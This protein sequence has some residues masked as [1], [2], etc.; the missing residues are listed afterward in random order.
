MWVVSFRSPHLR[1]EVQV[2][3]KRLTS[4]ST[5]LRCILFLLS[6]VATDLAG[7]LGMLKNILRIH[8]VPPRA[9][10]VYKHHA[11]GPIVAS[12]VTFVQLILKNLDKKT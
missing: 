8:P 6:Q 7:K 2:T 4:R 10:R 3:S 9:E 1:R 11:S 5:H 12:E